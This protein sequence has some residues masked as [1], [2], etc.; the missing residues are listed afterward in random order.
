MASEQQSGNYIAQ[1]SNRPF[2]S[3]GHSSDLRI[4]SIG[5]LSTICELTKPPELIL[6]VGEQGVSWEVGVWK[7]NNFIW[8]V[9]SWVE[10]RKL[11][12]AGPAG[13][14]SNIAVLSYNWWVYPFSFWPVGL[15]DLEALH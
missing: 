13:S 9:E 7:I 11:S 1:V 14:R 6:R 12:R 2:M 5:N 3:L 10:P 4:V 15:V 8:V